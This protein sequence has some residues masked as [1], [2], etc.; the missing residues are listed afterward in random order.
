MSIVIEESGVQFKHF[1]IEDCFH[2]EKSQLYQDLKHGVKMVEFILRRKDS[3][4]PTL[5]IIEAKSSSPNPKKVEKFGDFIGDIT[6][7]MN[8]AFSLLFALM[9]HRHP[10]YMEELPSSFDSE[11]IPSYAIRFVLVLPNHPKESLEPIKFALQQTLNATIKTW[12]LGPLAIT[13]LNRELAL[14]HSLILENSPTI[15]T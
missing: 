11:A 15:H 3:H 7:K 12:N 9:L 5:W 13:V 2:I 1:S 8:N 4:Q 10:Q 14:R 6:E